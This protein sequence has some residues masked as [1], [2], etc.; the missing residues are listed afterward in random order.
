MR[1]LNRLLETIL[2]R[3]HHKKVFFLS[4]NALVK[5]KIIIII[6][7]ITKN[8]VP[9]NGMGD[10]SSEEIWLLFVLFYPICQLV[11]RNINAS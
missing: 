6:I 4:I 7:I 9:S 8:K 10:V 3:V 2:L 11:D 1:P 5:F